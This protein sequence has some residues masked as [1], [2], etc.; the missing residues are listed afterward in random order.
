MKSPK[1]VETKR[2]ILKERDHD[3]GP[4]HSIRT[5][6]LWI[7]TPEKTQVYIQKEGHY[8]GR[9]VSYGSIPPK[10]KIDERTAELNISR[11]E[12]EIVSS[13]FRLGGEKIE[14][15]EKRIID[16][17]QEFKGMETFFFCI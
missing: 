1:L 15:T 11:K 16:L 5:H 7:I 2:I 14:L 3:F 10:V 6:K 13:S 4:N 8:E 12:G 17:M 9:D